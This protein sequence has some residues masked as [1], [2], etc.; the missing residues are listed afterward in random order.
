MVTHEGPGGGGETSGE[1][2]VPQGE[3][4]R[5]PLG[6][7]TTGM[8][9]D[10]SR[11]GGSLSRHGWSLSREGG[12]LSRDGGGASREDEDRGP[13]GI[14]GAPL[15]GTGVVL[16]LDRILLSP[17]SFPEITSGAPRP[18]SFRARRVG[19]VTN[20]GSPSAITALGH[21]SS[22]I[23]LLEA[24]VPLTRLF[25]PEHGLSAL[26]RDGSSV[27]D[28]WDRITGLPV[29]SLYG[30]RLTP[31]GELL[32]ALDLVLFDLQDV[33]AR[34]YTFL[35]TLSHLLESCA[36]ARVPLWVLDRPNPVGGRPEWVEGPLPDPHATPSFLGRWPVP[37]RHS[38]TLGEMARL[39]RAEMNLSVDLEVVRMEG[40]RREYLWPATGT[41]FHPPSPGIPSFESALLYPG[42]AFLEATNVSEGRGSELSFR[43]MGAP[44]MEAEVGAQAV[45]QEEFP[46]VRA[47]SR[48]LRRQGVICPGVEIQ[49][50][51]PGA[52][53]PVSLGLR[54]VALL[55][56][57]WP[58]RFGWSSYP[59]AANPEGGGHL[60]RLTGSAAAVKLLEEAP[61]AMTKDR[62]T[63]LTEAPGWWARAEPHLLYR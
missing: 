26:A 53:R 49:I 37:I 28:G 59:T 9:G 60:L 40:W 8:D 47:R 45:N 52:L 10:P 16:G 63:E 62:L 17:R 35:W 32:E 3:E 20:D 5:L 21:P 2:K 61:E 57:L 58:E 48:E 12:V 4:R 22:R 6:G 46:G 1:G 44:W 7:S 41:A 51:D 13:N 31:P 55:G 50:T 29:T 43:W 11:D 25:T 38:L 56:T 19:L 30:P 42:L 54:L 18:G 33:G 39:L 23:A 14:D 27:G 36:E 15:P 34:F 24:G